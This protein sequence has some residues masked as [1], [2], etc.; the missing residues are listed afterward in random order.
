MIKKST[1]LESSRNN[2][3]STLITGSSFGNNSDNRE[4]MDDLSLVARLWNDELAAAL[5]LDSRLNS[6]ER[7]NSLTDTDP[8]V[9]EVPD[10]SQSAEYSDPW[11]SKSAE[12]REETYFSYDKIDEDIRAAEEAASKK[13]LSTIREERESVSSTEAGA[14]PLGET[15]HSMLSQLQLKSRM[16]RHMQLSDSSDSSDDD[17]D[18]D[19]EEDVLVVDLENNRAVMMEGQSPRLKAAMASHN[20]EGIFGHKSNVPAETAHVRSLQVTAV[21]RLEIIESI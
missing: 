21:A 18:D 20:Y 13:D 4:W 14:T 10:T 17:I 3:D 7:N 1:F 8:H 5:A 12:I 15:G 2:V 19:D 11:P 6:T 16:Q 9:E